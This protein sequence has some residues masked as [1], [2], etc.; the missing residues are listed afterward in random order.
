MAIKSSEIEL[1][2][3]RYA[4]AVFFAAKKNSKL[5]QVLKDLNNISV[6]ISE[7]PEFEKILS[8]GAIVKDKMKSIFGAICDKAGVDAITKSFLEVIVENKRGSIIP[9]I[10]NK[11][12]GLILADSNTI[13]AT[14]ISS[15]KLDDA[16]LNKVKDSIAKQTGKKVLAENRVDNSI[17]GGLKVKIGSTLFDD[18]ISTKLERLKQSLA[19]N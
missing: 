12:E 10:S 14:V 15:K 19:T 4:K 2:S 16:A 1:L 13:K 17:I 9:Q 5:E 7:N 8:S 6:L 3:N 11:L 18:S